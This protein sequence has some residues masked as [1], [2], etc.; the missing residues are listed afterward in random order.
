MLKAMASNKR[1]RMKKTAAIAVLLIL[2][3]SLA[4]TTRLRWFSG[5]GNILFGSPAR[6]LF[7]QCSRSTPAGIRGFYL[8]ETADISNLEASLPVFL[9]A[10]GQKTA[11][12]QLSKY[13]L[14]YAGFI[15]ANRKLIYANAFPAAGRNTRSP[16][17]WRNRAYNVCDGGHDYFGFE[18]DPTTGKFARLEFNGPN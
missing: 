10:Q 3:L 18:F 14:Q 4:A 12:I 9:T 13:H 2:P 5:Q 6:A 16:L 15:R 11:H 8:P 1:L 17:F 7:N